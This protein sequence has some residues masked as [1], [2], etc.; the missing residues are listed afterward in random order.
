MKAFGSSYTDFAIAFQ[1][2]LL[3]FIENIKKYHI[4]I[5]NQE[6]DRSINQLK[7]QYETERDRRQE[8]EKINNQNIQLR[9]AFINPDDAGEHPHMELTI[10]RRTAMKQYYVYVV[11]WQIVNSRWHKQFPMNESKSSSDADVD[12]DDNSDVE[13]KPKKKKAQSKKSKKQ[14]DDTEPHKDGIYEPYDLF[15]VDLRTLKRNDKEEY[16]IYISPK[17][18]AES[19][20]SHFKFLRFIYIHNTAHYKEMMD[21]IANGKKYINESA[22]TVNPDLP[23]I[24]YI[25]EHVETAYKGVYQ[26]SYSNLM[27]ARSSSFI[28][29][30]KQIL[31]EHKKSKRT[32]VLQK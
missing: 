21:Y 26:L 25:P 8:A 16:Y 3:E 24:E 12:T 17:P 5:Y 30:N 18:V 22:Y 19:K 6:R 28:N 32:K 15:D 31:L 4:E 29:I 2:L 14:I 13:D 9:D 20:K 10:L 1:E 23:K 27:D 7:K 11:D